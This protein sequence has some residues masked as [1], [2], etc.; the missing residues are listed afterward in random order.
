MDRRGGGGGGLGGRGV[1]GGGTPP[2]PAVCGRSNTSQIPGPGHVQRTPQTPQTP[3]RSPRPPGVGGAS[4]A[5]GY[6]VRGLVTSPKHLRHQLRVLQPEAVRVGAD[7]PHERLV[8][9]ASGHVVSVA[10]AVEEAEQ[11]ALANCMWRAGGV[12][13]AAQCPA[14]EH[15]EGVSE[16]DYS[17]RARPASR[18]GPRVIPR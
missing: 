7:C 17:H 2:P 18:V 1:Q 12:G 15:W 3:P 10:Q 6:R 9:N 11:V 4:R 13:G 14:A 16:G 5:G 8:M